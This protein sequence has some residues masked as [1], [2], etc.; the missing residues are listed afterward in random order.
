MMKV[1]IACDGSKQSE[2]AL[3]YATRL[4]LKKPEFVPV[5]IA[6]LV[7]INPEF[8][9]Q[10]AR[11]EIDAFNK[12]LEK[13]GN[14]ALELAKKTLKELGFD[15][16]PEFIQGDPIYKLVELSKSYDLMVMGSRGLN[17]VQSFFLGS[18]SDAVVR[19][20]H[21]PVLLY[22]NDK[23]YPLP[24]GKFKILFGHGNTE[25]SEKAFDFLKALDLN[26]IKEIDL[27]SVMQMNYHYGMSYSIAALD[28]WPEHKATLEESLFGLQKTLLDS[29]K[30]MTVH[31]EIITDAYDIA[32]TLN[33]HAKEQNCNLIVTGSENKNFM[34]RIILGSTSNKLAHH[35]DLPVLIVR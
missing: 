1:L 11:D 4:P 33:K 20:S 25:S 32:N 9:R 26:N 17:P 5:N 13:Q 30:G 31:T 16:N 8:V 18:V 24:E 7:D 29:S 2:L 23:K 14:A 22:R 34:D 3:T 19:G 27:V 28:A 35:S 15:S 6:P 10:E 12:K 21:C